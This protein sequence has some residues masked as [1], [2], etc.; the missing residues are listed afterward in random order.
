MEFAHRNLPKESFK[1]PDS[2]YSATISSISGKLASEKTPEHFRV[3][4]IFAVKPTAYE[5]SMEE[6]EVDALCNGKVTSST[7]TDSIKRGYLVNVN[8]IIDSYQNDWLA[9]IR[10]WVKSEAGSAY[11]SEAKGNIITDYEDKVCER[12][13]SSLSRISLSTNLDAVDVRP[14]GPNAIEVSYE[15]EF[16]IVKLKFERNGELFKEVAVEGE[17]T[18]GTYRSSVFDF[19][20][21]FLGEHTLSIVAVDKYGYTGRTS[22]TVRF[23]KGSND[24][25]VITVTNPQNGSV[26]IYSD[27]F[28]NLRFEV[29]DAQEIVANNLL[30]DGKLWKIL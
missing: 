9:S 11:F 4:S 27:Q 25:P 13:G 2:V 18:S 1:K 5:N 16:P 8:P 20:E 3:S 29:A 28:F 10:S 15:S 19:D 24:D 12:P 30:L 6:I 17:K 7:P 26:K 21:S 22:T 23:A 14:L